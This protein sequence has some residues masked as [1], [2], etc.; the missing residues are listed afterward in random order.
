MGNT[1]T[2][3]KI[4]TIAGTMFSAGNAFIGSLALEDLL[5]ALM[6][7]ITLVAAKKRFGPTDSI[8]SRLTKDSMAVK[9]YVT[10]Q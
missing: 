4:A 5:L 9:K 7:A 10:G 3:L 1:Y 6:V 8:N 2:I